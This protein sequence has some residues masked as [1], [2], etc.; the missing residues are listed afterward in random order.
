M[1]NIRTFS[2]LIGVLACLAGAAHQA[3]AEFLFNQFLEPAFSVDPGVPNKEYSKWDLFY[4]ASG[5]VNYPDAAAP[6]GTKTPASEAT[7]PFIPPV[8]STPDDPTAYWNVNNPTISQ[9]N[10]TAFIAGGAAQANIYSF[11]AKTSFTLADTTPYTVGTVVFQFQTDGT[12]V[13]FDS[14]KLVY[15]NGSGD[16]QISASEAIREYRSSGSSFGGVTNRNALQWDLGGLG[17]SSYR[18]V[19]ESEAPS[20]SFQMAYLDTTDITASGVPASRTW[21][22]G[23]GVWSQG[24]NWSQGSTSVTNGNVRFANTGPATVTLDGNRQVGEIIFDTASPVEI[25]SSGGA[26]LTGNTGV[27][28]T[29]AATGTYTIGADY[30][31]NAFNMFDVK[32]GT[33]VLAG[34]V[35]GNYGFQKRGGGTLVL[36]G[37]NS[38]TGSVDVG[39]GILRMEGQ[40]QY[41]GATSIQGGRLIVSSDVPASGSGPLGNASSNI[42]LGADDITTENQTVPAASLWIEGD[43]T[44]ARGV[45]VNTGTNEMKLGA[46]GTVNGAVYSGAI[47]LGPVG[48]VKLTAEAASDKLIFSGAMTGG[49][50]SRTVTLDGQGTVIYSG[51]NKTYASATAVNSGT[52]VIQSGTSFTGNGN[53]TVANGARLKVDGTLGGTGALT[54]NGGT[55]TGSGTIGRTFVADAGD[56]LSP[57]N[58][59]GTLNTA[60]ET[61]GG[62]ATYLWEIGDVDAGAGTGWDRIN[63]TGNLNITADNSN[64]FTLQITSLD[65]LNALGLVGD[66]NSNLNYSWIIASA[67][68]GIS[69][70]SA[71]SFLL[72]TDDFLNSLNGTFSLSQVGNDLVLN[73][74][75][76]PEPSTYVLLGLGLLLVGAWKRRNLKLRAAQ[77]PVEKRR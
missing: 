45:T 32:G 42:V 29:A 60:S 43:H 47:N 2:V 71:S 23:N 54:L 49:H 26:A 18:I 28:T 63:I 52:L 46:S 41:T 67:S 44:V 37:D 64:R 17:I 1:K 73:Y 58:S 50:T 6:N 66:F 70:F 59:P 61:W 30:I 4:S 74:T 16:V 31:L 51:A 5:G 14:I 27:S 12:L 72:D 76:V 55:L 19:F 68:L 15:N 75:A 56:V 57:G 20:M 13:D 3:R 10:T 8:G 25:T 77:V 33:V 40:N 21:T 36:S 39:A 7:P 34:T 65:A 22:A 38:F 48:N 24:S 11:Q 62:G 35:S 9:S 69:G 53:M